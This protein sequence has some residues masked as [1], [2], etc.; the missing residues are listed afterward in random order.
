VES[1]SREVELPNGFPKTEQ[2]AV[3]GCLSLA[4]PPAFIAKVW[5]TAAGRGGRDA[6]D[7]P[8]RNWV[9]HVSAAWKYQ[10]ER[11]AKNPVEKSNGSDPKPEWRFW[12]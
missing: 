9:R 7:V 11:D 2:E 12:E 5:D 4:C 8:I 10:Q 1:G 3:S 6:K